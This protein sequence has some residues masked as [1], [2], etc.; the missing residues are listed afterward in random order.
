ML[1]EMVKNVRRRPIFESATVERTEPKILPLIVENNGRH[2]VKNLRLG[3]TGL[4]ETI[5]HTTKGEPVLVA[6]K[7]PIGKEDKDTVKVVIL[8]VAHFSDKEP[9]GPVKKSPVINLDQDISKP[10]YFTHI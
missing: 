2:E 5:Q 1:E 3:D 9:S 4:E 10:W 8:T 7:H 6:S